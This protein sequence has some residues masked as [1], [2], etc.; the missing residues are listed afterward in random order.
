MNFSR[1]LS[2]FFALALGVGLF[3]SITSRA[4]AEDRVPG[5]T[6]LEEKGQSDAESKRVTVKNAKG[7]LVAKVVHFTD[8][9]VF[10]E[11]FRADGTLEFSHEVYRNG[12]QREHINYDGTGKSV[13]DRKTWRSDGTLDWEA[14]TK[15]DGNTLLKEYYDDG[16]LLRKEREL[17]DKGGFSETTYRK[18]GTKWYGSQRAP[19]EK[20]RGVSMFF[21]A[22]GESLRR[23]TKGTTMTVIVLDKNDRE[24]YTQTWVSGIAG[25]V[26]SSV[27]EPV[28][29]GGWR[30][31][32]LLG[33][34]VDKVEYFKANGTLDRTEQGNALTTPVDQG[35]LKEYSSEDPT[36]PRVHATR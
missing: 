5:Y 23:H 2:G 32:H 8:G 30:I 18:D 31:I 29:G 11:V 9:R 27:K 26:L 7:V 15:P 1:I 3:G 24:V 14:K 10:R 16:K 21:A 33:K 22:N 6:Y 25:Y 4:S 36:S 28:P 34:N 19:G 17:F 13:T 35:R 12:Q 20:G